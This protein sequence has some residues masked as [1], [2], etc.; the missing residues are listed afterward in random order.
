MNKPDQN[1]QTIYDLYN[2][3]NFP[4]LRIHSLY[5]K[6]IQS[7]ENNIITIISTKSGS[8]KSTQVPIF[9][10]DLLSRKK[11]A[12]CIICTEPRAIACDTL[13]DYII[14]INNKFRIYNNISGYH[15]TFEKKLFFL[16]ESDLLKLLKE[17]PYLSKCDILILDEV[18][19]RTMKLELILYYMKYFTLSEENIQR[20]F[21][22]ILMSATFNSDGIYSY[23]SSMKE[24]KFT[25]GFIDDREL[26]EGEE[27]NY[28]I[29]YSDSINSNGLDCGNIKF[30]DLN[31]SKLIGEI[32]KIVRYEIYLNN[33]FNKTII[34]FLPDYKTIYL[35][36]NLLSKEY[37]NYTVH[38]Y[39]FISSL[40]ISQ[41]NDLLYFNLL[42][43][44]KFELLLKF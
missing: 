26:T 6:I 10:Y 4:S 1:Q 21:K 2:Y 16:E 14:S 3:Y 15:K 9:S 12:F 31:M 39:Q 44:H 13:N 23:F 35:L 8:G 27:E 33:N 40:S 7:I 25:F 41:Q 29:V 20:G 37:N 24:N 36:Y 5:P 30:K 17:D 28:E 22:L 43:C 32:I 11:N 18:H 34:I 19:E 38:I 42:S